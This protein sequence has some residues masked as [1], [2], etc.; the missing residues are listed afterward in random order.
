MTFFRELGDQQRIAQALSNLALAV[1]REGD[2]ARAVTLFEE[3]LAI[4]RGLGDARSLAITLA[5]FALL[6][7]EQRDDGRAAALL[8]ESIALGR[9]IENPAILR[10]GLRKLAELLLA[11]RRP[12]TAAKLIGAADSFGDDGDGPAPQPGS[13]TEH[14]TATAART[15]LGDA[16]YAVAWTAGRALS[17]DQAVAEA[18]QA[19]EE[20]AKGGSDSPPTAAALP[21]IIANLTPREREVLRL[22]VEGRTDREI[23]EAIFVTTKTASNHVASI[24]AKLGADTRTAAAALALRH[25]LA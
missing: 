7:R 2:H 14:P 6:V 12:A 10:T 8:V 21:S 17:P 24:L 3:A 15:A 5:D 9:L 19:A 18:A 23:G 1:Q 22:L 11:H 25:G 20:L 4:Q 13:T 16:P